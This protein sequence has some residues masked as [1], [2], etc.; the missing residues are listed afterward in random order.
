MKAGLDVG[1]K[2]PEDQMRPRGEKDGKDFTREGAGTRKKSAGD[3]AEVEA[4]FCLLCVES[5]I[6]L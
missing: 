5:W 6:G 4:E 1:K 2:D 3:S